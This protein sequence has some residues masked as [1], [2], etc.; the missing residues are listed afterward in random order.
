VA[1]DS[2]AL[3]VLV[4]HVLVLVDVT[5]DSQHVEVHIDRQNRVVRLQ[6]KRCF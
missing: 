2:D 6:I 4:P 3:F 1:H 5:V